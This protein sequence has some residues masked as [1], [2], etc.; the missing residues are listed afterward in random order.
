M[1]SACAF[2]CAL[3]SSLRQALRHTSLA[4]LRVGRMVISMQ[5]R[6]ELDKCYSVVRQDAASYISSY[7]NSG[8]RLSAIFKSREIRQSHSYSKGFGCS[9]D[10][11][12]LSNL[13]ESVSTLDMSYRKQV[14]V[15]GVPAIANFPFPKYFINRFSHNTKDLVSFLRMIFRIALQPAT[16]RQFPVYHLVDY[17]VN[18]LHQVVVRINNCAGRFTRLTGLGRY[19]FAYYYSRVWSVYK[20]Y[21]FKHSYDDVGCNADYLDHYSNIADYVFGVI[22]SPSLDA[23]GFDKSDYCTDFNNLVILYKRLIG[24]SNC[25]INYVNSVM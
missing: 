3:V 10:Y 15:D 1:F 17:N 5:I 18:D 6:R 2:P 9:S 7:V 4:F 21:L 20:S 19:D 25:M 12:S 8:N 22:R 14:I 13:L 11:F 24:W 16:I 23:L